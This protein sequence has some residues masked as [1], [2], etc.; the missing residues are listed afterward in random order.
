MEGHSLQGYG[1]HDPGGPG[2]ESRGQEI[3]NHR[4]RSYSYIILI[5]LS[6]PHKLARNTF[7]VDHFYT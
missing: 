5:T 3:Q 2:Q 1:G 6:L 4:V 7:Y